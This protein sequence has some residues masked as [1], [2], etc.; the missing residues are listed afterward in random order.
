MPENIIEY[1]ALYCPNKSPLDELEEQLKIRR[2]YDIEMLS[3]YRMIVGTTGSMI[4]LVENSKN[5]YDFVILD[6]ACQ[7]TEV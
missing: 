2:I 4:S 5:V 1:S 3:E 7:A 6:E